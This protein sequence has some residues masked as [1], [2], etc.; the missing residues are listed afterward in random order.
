MNGK[1]IEIFAPFEAAMETTKQILFRPF[2]LTKWLTIGFCAFLA[3][4][5]DAS[6]GGFNFN[7]RTNYNTPLG[8]GTQD[9][10]KVRDQLRDLIPSWLTLN[11][12][13]CLADTNFL[14]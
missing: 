4:L 1:K 9:W 7:Y 10:G 2:D 5:S 3:G 14:I 6:H 8:K 13:L 11:V 12:V